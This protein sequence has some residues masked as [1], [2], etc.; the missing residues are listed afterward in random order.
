M[1]K[2]SLKG[3]DTRSIC[4][5]VPYNEVNWLEKLKKRQRTPGIHIRSIKETR[6]NY[7][8]ERPSRQE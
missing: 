8:W 3:D 2:E 1:R 4:S 5:E 7:T 6:T